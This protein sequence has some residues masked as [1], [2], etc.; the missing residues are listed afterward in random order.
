MRIGLSVPNA[1][2]EGETLVDAVRVVEMAALTPPPVDGAE[3]LALNDFTGLPPGAFTPERFGQSGKW[4]LGY[5]PHAQFDVLAAGNEGRPALHVVS[6]PGEYAALGVLP[7]AR[8]QRGGLYRVTITARGQAS[9]S[10]NFWAIPWGLTPVRHWDLTDEWK[11][12]S[13]DFF[14]DTDAEA[15]AVPVVGVTGEAWLD[16]MEM[17]VAG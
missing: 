8:L 6:G 5:G 12:Y 13:L 14:I 7:K 4:T 2:A 1:K 11:T 15:P 17:K 3:L 16:R 10:L 9:L